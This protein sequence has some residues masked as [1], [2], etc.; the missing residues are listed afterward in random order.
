[1]AFET[2][3]T[4]V[5]ASPDGTGYLSSKLSQFLM[6]PA[7]AKGIGGF[8]FDYEGEGT[9][10]IQAEISD[11]YLEDNSAV[12]DHMAIKPLRLVLSGFNGEL[13]DEGTGT[14]P[15]AALNALQNRLTVV[16]AYLGKYTPAG[17]GKVQG[18]LKK[19]TDIAHTVDQT[20]KK[21]SNLAS[22]FL[23]SN[24]ART[25]TQIAFLDIYARM[26]SKQIMVVDGPFGA[27]PN[28]VVENATM[29]QDE[30]TKDWVDII[31]TLKQ[32]RFVTTNFDQSNKNLNANTMGRT[33]TKNGGSTVGTKV[34]VPKSQEQFVNQTPRG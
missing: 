14:G 17:I 31:V 9:A 7:N 21:V 10:K 8:V 23:D 30:T 18:V 28:M 5:S 3:Q 20:L 32:L 15:I 11:H 19:A 24:P 2:L 26:L 6:R 12:N 25:A 33:P 13:V 34:P 4:G 29:I 16:P 27:F 22:F 1:M